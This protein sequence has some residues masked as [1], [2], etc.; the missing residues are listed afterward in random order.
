MTRRIPLVIGVVMIVLGAY[1]ALHPLWAPQRPLT[2]SRWLDV[3]FA[4][5]FLIKGWLNVRTAR[6]DRRPHAP[7]A[8]GAPRA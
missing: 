1:V 6:R 7:G 2:A 4:A 5:F 8:D 3:T